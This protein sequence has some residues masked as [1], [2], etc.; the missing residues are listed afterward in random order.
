MEVV[1]NGAVGD[2]NDQ[3][4]NQ[5]VVTG[6][7]GEGDGTHGAKKDKGVNADG[8]DDCPDPGVLEERNMPMIPGKTCN[9]IIK[10]NLGQRRVNAIP[11]K[12]HQH[13]PR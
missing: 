11:G 13:Q 5:D 3:H 8:E 6:L 2:N 12:Q 9:Q 1:V 7:G 10:G 4:G